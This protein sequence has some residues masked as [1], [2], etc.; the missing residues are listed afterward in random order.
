MAEQLDSAEGLPLPEEQQAKRARLETRW[1]QAARAMDL[2]QRQMQDAVAAAQAVAS[3]A[4]QMARSAAP[5]G[6]EGADRA[7]SGG[8]TSTPP[9]QAPLIASS[10]PPLG[11]LTADESKSIM[12]STKGFEASVQKLLKCNTKVDKGKDELQFSAEDT[13]NTR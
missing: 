5:V 8:A 4:G 12:A 1:H 10:S 7:R 11:K 13:T 3:L 6:A 9:V 2:Q